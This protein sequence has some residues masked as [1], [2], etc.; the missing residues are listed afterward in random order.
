MENYNNIIC[1][2][3]KWGSKVRGPQGPKVDLPRQARPDNL[4]P[5]MGFILTQATTNDHNE[6]I[7]MYIIYFRKRLVIR[8]I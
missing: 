7:E 1:N 3:V 8:I 5:P 2:N 6:L 4:P